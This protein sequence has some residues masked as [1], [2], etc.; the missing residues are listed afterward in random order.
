MKKYE[1]FVD[2]QPMIISLDQNWYNPFIKEWFKPDIYPEMEEGDFGYDDDVYRMYLVNESGA[3]LGV[4]FKSDYIGKKM[5]A[6][7]K[8]GNWDS[9]NEDDW[10]DNKTLFG[11][12]IN[13]QEVFDT[14]CLLLLEDF[15]RPSNPNKT[16]FDEQFCFSEFGKKVS[17]FFSNGE[18]NMDRFSL[19]CA[20][21]T[22][23][24]DWWCDS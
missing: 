6:W 21:T 13:T 19:D 16:K 1:D 10:P 4:Y 8:T 24:K 20:L 17:D 12:F 18:V 7:S 3:Y 9:D 5:D 22:D 15:W 2:A 23:G 11:E 14:L